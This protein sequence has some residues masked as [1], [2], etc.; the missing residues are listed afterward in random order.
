MS[1]DARDFD[2]AD[3]ICC[4]TSAEAHPDAFEVNSPRSDRALLEFSRLHRT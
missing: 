4:A 3:A 1:D 2:E